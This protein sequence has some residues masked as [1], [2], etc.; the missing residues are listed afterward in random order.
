MSR[1][2]IHQTVITPN[3]NTYPVQQ[4]RKLVFIIQNKTAEMHHKTLFT[5][6]NTCS[7]SNFTGRL[8][9]DI[10]QTALQIR[11]RFRQQRR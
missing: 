5:A 1:N 7:D 9:K 4:K 11:S 8:H 6:A 10:V 3:K 2:H